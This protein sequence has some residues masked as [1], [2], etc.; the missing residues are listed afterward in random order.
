RSSRWRS[1][2]RSAG[3]APPPRPAEL[4]RASPRRLRRRSQQEPEREPPEGCAGAHL[5]TSRKIQGADSGWSQ[6]R[7]CQFSFVPD[8]LTRGEDR[9]REVRGR[10]PVNFP[11][12]ARG[13]THRD[14][15]CARCGG[16]AE[17]GTSVRTDRVE[18]LAA[19]LEVILPAQR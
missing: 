7:F 9:Q 13:K 4:D 15:E 18:K 16:G 14:D 19:A 10:A 12:P 8:A 5:P 3:R 17:R 1:S 2:P 6:V 11:R